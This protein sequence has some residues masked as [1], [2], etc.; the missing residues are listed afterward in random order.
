MTL[1]DIAGH[2]HHARVPVIECEVDRATGRVLLDVPLH[3]IE[4]RVHVV[5]L[6]IHAALL[7]QPV[8]VVD[9]PAVGLLI[10]ADQPPV[11][12]QVRATKWVAGHVVG[13]GGA[14]VL[15][16]TGGYE[17]IAGE[18]VRADETA[19]IEVVML[20]PAVVRDLMSRMRFDHRE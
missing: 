14:E 6:G 16:T 19:G 10:G 15:Q 9:V 1:V 13:S 5:A 18:H 8:H 12:S 11:H 4:Q 2:D 17:T 3:V 7:M 20:V